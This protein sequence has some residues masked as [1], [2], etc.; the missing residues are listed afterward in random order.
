MKRIKNFL[1]ASILIFASFLPIIKPEN[2]SANANDFY[3]KSFNADYY[4]KK[5]DDNTSEMEVTETLT[6]VFPNYNQNHGIERRIPFL[7]QNDTNLTME[8]TDHLAISVTRN[9]VSEKFKVTAH[10]TYFNVRI[11]DADTYLHGEQTYVLKYKFVHVITDFSSSGYSAYPYQELYWDANGTG[12]DQSF[13][14]VNVNLHMDDEILKNIKADTTIS[15]TS[16]YKDKSTIHENNTTKDKLAAWCYVGRYGESGQN[17]CK[18]TDI[19]D[20]INFN[21]KNLSGSEN[22]T[23]VANFNDGTFSIPDN[24]YIKKRVIKDLTVDY[25]LSKNSDGTSNIKVKEKVVADFP[26]PNIDY[27]LVRRIPFVNQGGTNFITDSQEEIDLKAT[28][29]GKPVEYS[30]TSKDG[31]F[32]IIT[33]KSGN[34]IH[35]RHTLE[36]EYTFKNIVTQTE[37]DSEKIFQNFTIGERS[38]WYDDIEKLVV[39]V[40]LTDELQSRLKAVSVK[41]KEKDALLKEDLYGKAWCYGSIARG[42]STSVCKTEE[43]A[44]GF[45]FS[46]NSLKENTD[47]LFSVNFEDKTFV[48]PP[49]NRNYIFYIVFA[50]VTAILTFISIRFY[51]KSYKDVE[52]KIK[53]LKNKPTPPQY[54][55]LKDYT[56]AQMARAYVKPTKN[57]KVATMLELIVN[58]KIELIKG[59]RKFFGGYNW[60]V[61]IVSLTDLSNEQR[62]L[63]TILNNGISVEHPGK[64]IDVKSHSYS[65]SL[66]SAFRRYDT[67][68][69]G[70]LKDS[71]CFEKETNNLKKTPFGNLGFVF[72]VMFIFLFSPL[73]LGIAAAIIY[74][75]IS[76]FLK[77]INFTPYSIYEGK[78]LLPIM[79]IMAL[80]VFTAIP[81]LS[82]FFAKY[83]KRTKEGLELSNYMDGLKLYIKM[84]E[85]DRLKFLQSVKG[86]DTSEEGIVKLYEKLLPYAALFGLEKSWMNELGK[87]YELT[88]TTTPDWYASGFTYSAINSTMR[89]ALSRP[90]DTSSSSGG[91]SGGHSSGS[92]GGGGGGF[93]GGGGGGGGGGGW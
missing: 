57:S 15:K 24:D 59:D 27:G 14:E 49:P 23:F 39:N 72:L 17:R 29:D 92:S 93:S 85:T 32:N 2:A 71:G 43:I 91:G 78:F 60:K 66:D 48:L 35:G 34:Y 42:Y 25:Y 80:I 18:I 10:D 45:S 4:L 53:Y 89:S 16:S 47:L 31:A 58:K 37:D 3:F 55:P 20:G 33:G 54:T 64:I 22:L 62:D 38:F 44:D 82:G 83:K 63:I 56:A 9:G 7:N 40:H 19:K 67:H 51:K 21:A 46:M 13:Q 70:D 76:S 52:E 75:A 81:I 88:K 8:S 61:K 77:V 26:T 87:Y 50:I 11:G 41:Q 84:A 69:E 12:W 36:F 74:A 90:I 65:S 6:A 73:F 68:I 1:F 28:I 86:V 5:Q 30:T 79:I